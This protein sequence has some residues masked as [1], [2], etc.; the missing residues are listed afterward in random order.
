[1][2]IYEVESEVE[3]LQ[4]LLLETLMR[5]FQTL[6]SITE[7]DRKA[8]TLL[9]KTCNVK[10]IQVIICMYG[11]RPSMNQASKQWQF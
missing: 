3:W 7:R 2:R 11:V 8:V 6:L 9:L 10:V 1:M 5:L 4:I